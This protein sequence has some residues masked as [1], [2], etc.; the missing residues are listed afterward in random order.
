[1]LLACYLHA[2]EEL[3]QLKQL[4][5]QQQKQQQQQQQQFSFDVASDLGRTLLGF[6]VH[7]S[8]SDRLNKFTV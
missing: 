8:S 5:Q 4:K 3:Y 7:Y 1:V 2:L 6:F